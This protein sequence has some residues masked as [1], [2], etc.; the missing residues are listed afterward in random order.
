M[1]SNF[2]EMPSNFFYLIFYRE[3]DSEA[4]PIPSPSNS[5]KTYAEMIDIDLPRT[6]SEVIKTIVASS[7]CEYT[8]RLHVFRAWLWRY[9][10]KN[11]TAPFPFTFLYQDFRR[12]RRLFHKSFSHD[13]REEKRTKRL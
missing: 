1:T 7:N 5:A 3:E 2:R 6:L 10:F 13:T 8:L 12:S 11:N 4:D 9:L